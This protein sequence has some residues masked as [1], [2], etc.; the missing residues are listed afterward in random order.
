MPSLEKQEQIQR[1]MQQDDRPKFGQHR[2]VHNNL[3]SQSVG[4]IGALNQSEVSALK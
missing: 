3:R 1:I 2:V 4:G